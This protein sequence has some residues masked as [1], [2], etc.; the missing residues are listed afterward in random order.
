[1]RIHSLVAAAAMLSASLTAQADTVYTYT[2]LDFISANGPFTTADS[3][4]GSFTL[5]NPLVGN[6]SNVNVVP[7][8]FSFNDGVET[9]S[10][11]TSVGYFPGISTNANG[12][13]T[14]WI[15]T[16][17]A[18]DKIDE[19]QVFN[20]YIA[21]EGLYDYD[22]AVI[23]NTTDNPYGIGPN[24]YG[25]T[26]DGPGT[27]TSSASSAVTPEPSSIALLGT[28]LLGIVGVVRKRFA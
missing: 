11:G 25:A 23:E 10:S 16:I 12:V 19:L 3:V 13:I 7:L 1:M 17:V 26:S 2:G 8:S 4:K 5:A 22:K 15:I 14:Q 18:A 9:F 6:L 27:F 28:G 24:V 21:G 20:E